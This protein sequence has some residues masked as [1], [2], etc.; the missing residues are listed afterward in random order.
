MNTTNR[1]WRI[2]GGVLAV[3]IAA[4][5]LTVYA[6]KSN[7]AKKAN[8]AAI[9]VDTVKRGPLTISVTVSGTIRSRQQEVIKSE[10]EGMPTVLF[11]IPEGTRVKKGDLLVELDVS[12]LQ[13]SKVSQQIVVQNAEA[14]AISARESLEVAKSQAKSD[15]AKAELDYQF[16]KE[17]LVKYQEGD[18]KNAVKEAENKIMLAQNDLALAQIKAESS[19]KLNQEKFLSNMEY[20]AD[21]LA[22]KR[23]ESSLMLAQNAHRLLTEFTFKRQMTTL[24][25]AVDQA[26]MALDRVK[27]KAAAD[28]VQAEAALRAKESEFE[29]QKMILDKT[30]LMITKAKMYAP[31]DGLVVYATT[32]GGGFRGDRE[33]LAEGSTVRERQEIIYLPTADS[34][35]A[36]VKVHESSLDKVRLEL[37][38]RVTVDAVPNK[39]FMGRVKKIAPLPDQQSM[40]QN[41]DLKVYNTEIWLEGDGSDLRT[42]MTCRAEIIVDYYPDAL[43]VPIP[44]VVRVGGQP[45]VYIPGPQGL[46]PRAVE[47]GLDNNS[48]IRILKGLEAGETVALAPPLADAAVVNDEQNK[49]PPLPAGVTFPATRPTGAGVGNGDREGRQSGGRG[50]GAGQGRRGGFDPANMTEEQRAAMEARRRQFEAMTPEEREKLREQMRQGGGRPPRLGPTT[51]PASPS[52]L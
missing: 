45:T 6:T 14:A 36:A 42:G 16:A 32:G 8:L 44:A 19:K 52:P 26:A 17:D 2:I 51:A 39:V 25:A 43:Y 22:M 10:V 29:R 5:A 34:V 13:D 4:G 31:T 30:N 27:R 7:S 48:R 3:V 15:T 37:P 49:A 47:V 20:E 35:M 40:W 23:A 46:V 9:P 21:L 28:V 12:K 11:L 50:G 24:G 38:V 41:P 18:Y 1:S 33:P